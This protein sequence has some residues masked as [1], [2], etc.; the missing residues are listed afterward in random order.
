MTTKKILIRDLSVFFIILLSTLYITAINARDIDGVTLPDKVTLK[1]TDVELQ[2]NGIGYR[3]K[4][5]FKVYVGALYTETKVNSRDA[6]QALTGPKRIAMH[7]VYDEVGR[8]KMSKAWHEGFAENNSDAQL[9][10]LQT[11]LDTFVNY[12]PDLKAGDQVLLDYIPV[13][14]TH[15][16]ING[17]EKGVIEGD[18]FYRALLDVWLG[19][20]PADNDL[21]DAMLGAAEE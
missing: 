18:D 20:E 13:S 3:T 15:V 6:V 8:E 16:T 11:R 19:D 17:E 2:L 7:I 1:N 5:V 12:F 10:K 4:F 21:K 9:A 14:G